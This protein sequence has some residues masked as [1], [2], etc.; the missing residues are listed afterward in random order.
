MKK[1]LAAIFGM[2]MLFGFTGCTLDFDASEEP[3]TE[4]ENIT[5]EETEKEELVPLLAENEEEQLY[6]YG[7]KPDGVILYADGEG[8]YY[9]WAYSCSD[10]KAPKLFRGYFDGDNTEDIAVVTYTKNEN[11]D[12][13]DLRIISD[14]DFDAESVYLIDEDEYNSYVSHHID[15]SYANNAVTFTLGEINYSFDLSESFSKLVFD[16]VSYSE[17]VKYE[18][19]DGDIYVNIIPVVYS[20]DEYNDYGKSNVDIIIRAKLLFDGYNISLAEA[21]IKPL[22]MQNG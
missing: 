6:L 17:N 11:A 13:E 19:S 22:L 20:G 8:H 16:G 7:I 21:E 1:I 15:Y 14:G 12:V 3:Q 4:L 5:E 10:Y 9:D 18:F 2:V